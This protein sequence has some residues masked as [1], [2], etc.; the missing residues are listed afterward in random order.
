MGA[1]T[2]VIGVMGPHLNRQY[3]NEDIGQQIG[4]FSER[5]VEWKVDH[6]CAIVVCVTRVIHCSKA[7]IIPTQ[8]EYLISNLPGEAQA[9]V[10]P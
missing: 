5:T 2:R 4:V 7:Q 6:L 3:V 9:E 8:A 10:H 1:Q